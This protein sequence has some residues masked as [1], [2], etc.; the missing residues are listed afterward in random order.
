MEL[1]YIAQQLGVPVKEVAINWQEI[2][3]K[4]HMI[5]LLLTSSHHLILY[6]IQD[7]PNSELD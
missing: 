1:L 5:P 2:E 6:R 7:G 4:A 3:G